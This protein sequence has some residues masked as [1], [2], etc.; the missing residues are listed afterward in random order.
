MSE[1]IRKMIVKGNLHMNTHFQDYSKW[2]TQ[3]LLKDLQF[4]TEEAAVNG[5]DI[6]HRM[7][8]VA[9]IIRIESELI[10][11][12]ALPPKPVSYPRHGQIR[13]GPKNLR[14]L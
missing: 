14:V 12:G 2:S 7:K 6:K 10:E 5:W 3:D 1:T 4:W 11:R 13:Y 9:L 8:M